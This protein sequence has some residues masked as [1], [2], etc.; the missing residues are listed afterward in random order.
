[1]PDYPIKEV[2]IYNTNLKLIQP[3]G[4]I[5]YLSWEYQILLFGPKYN[6][7]MIFYIH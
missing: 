6:L 4:N 5:K 7:P 2:L 3:K 1:M